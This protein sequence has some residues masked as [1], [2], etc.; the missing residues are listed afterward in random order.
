MDLSQSSVLVT[1][2]GS[3]LGRVLAADFAAAGA[4]VHIA[5]GGA[6]RWMRWLQPTL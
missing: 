4:Q 3:G 5:G 2:G 6:S 1:G